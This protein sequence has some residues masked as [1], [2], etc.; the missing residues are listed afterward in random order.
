[1]QTVSRRSLNSRLLRWHEVRRRPLL[2]RE[3]TDPW[4]VLVA[5]VMS[6]QTGIERVGPAWR[7]FLDQWPTP[8]HLSEAGTHELLAAWSGLGYNRRALALRE[9]AQT[10][11]ARH[12][13]RVPA[14]VAELESLPGIGPYTARAV[15]AAGFGVPVA[16]LD[17]NVRRVVSR[18]LGVASSSPG[19]QA[20]ADELVARGRPGRWLDAVMDL[21][22]AI[23]APRAPLCD[24]CPLATV[25]A[26]RGVVVGDE[27]K[28]AAIPFAMTNR[29][30]RGRL[31]AAVT[32]A[33][34]GTWV[35]LPE[36]LGHHDSDAVAAAARGLEREG[37]LDLG[38]G[39][40]RVRQ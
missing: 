11:V 21:A 5:E 25:C 28:A 6:Q 36:R 35:P 38:A 3:A 12:R 15:A 24:A 19:L 16:P 22:S 30:L 31:V 9:S 7:R 40:A 29:W 17:V 39:S 18:V 1:M 4:Q 8:A 33:P 13:G 26:S 32:A 34:A 23:C 20:Q 2:I 27:P 37:F 10:I 14:T